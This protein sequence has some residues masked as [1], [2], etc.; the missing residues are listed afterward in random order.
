VS[1]NRSFDFNPPVVETD[2]FTLDEGSA[3][4]AFAVGSASND[5]LG[6]I[7]VVTNPVE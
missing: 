6:A 3:Y 7:V 2:P 4:A 1:R 5:A